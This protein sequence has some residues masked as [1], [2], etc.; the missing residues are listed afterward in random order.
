MSD[1][2]KKLLKH[3]SQVEDPDTLTHIL[4]MADHIIVDNPAELRAVKAE[5]LTSAILFDGAKIRSWDA[6]RKLI[7]PVLLSQDPELLG[8]MIDVIARRVDA[9]PLDTVFPDLYPDMSYVLRE[10]NK[11]LHILVSLGIISARAET[12]EASKQLVDKINLLRHDARFESVADDV[13][14]ELGTWDPDKIAEKA[15]LHSFIQTDEARTGQAVDPGASIDFT[16]STVDAAAD[17]LGLKSLGVHR[18]ETGAVIRHKSKWAE[19]ADPGDPHVPESVYLWFELE[20]SPEMRQALNQLPQSAAW[21]RRRYDDLD[22]PV[23]PLTKVPSLNAINDEYLRQLKADDNFQRLD[24]GRWTGVLRSIRDSGSPLMVQK[25]SDKEY[26]LFL[27]VHARTSVLDHTR[28]GILFQK[29]PLGEAR[30]SWRLEDG[31][32]IITAL[33]EPDFTSFIHEMGHLLRRDLNQQQLEQMASWLKTKNIEVEID[34]M[35]RFIGDPSVVENAEETFAKAFEVYM[36]TRNTDS[37]WVSRMFQDIQNALGDL[38][39][40]IN[41]EAVTPDD[42]MVQ[43]FDNLVSDHENIL[44]TPTRSA[45]HYFT[46]LTRSL[47]RTLRGRFTQNDGIAKDSAASYIVREARHDER[48]LSIYSVNEAGEALE[49]LTTPRQVSRV[50]E[51]GRNIAFF[52]KPEETTGLENL[53]QVTPP[54]RIGKPQGTDPKDNVFTPDH[55]ERLTRTLTDKLAAGPRES[56]AVTNIAQA[57]TGDDI[58]D[59]MRRNIE[60]KGVARKI[61]RGVLTTFVGGDPFNV[62]GLSALPDITRKAILAGTRLVENAYGEASRLIVDASVDKDWAKVYAF[63]AGDPVT[64]KKGRQVV[65]SGYNSMEQAQLSLA[66]WFKTSGLNEQWGVISENFHAGRSA[67]QLDPDALDAIIG[68]FTDSK[69]PDFL[70]RIL[71]SMT[72]GKPLRETGARINETDLKVL[73]KIFVHL[74]VVDDGTGIKPPPTAVKDWTQRTQKLFED[75]DAVAGEKGPEMKSRITMLI[76]GFGNL[77]RAVDT[78]SGLG[79]MQSADAVKSFTRYLDA[80]PLTPAEMTQA[81]RLSS[82]FGLNKEFVE[83]DGLFRSFEGYSIPE[84]A[85]GKLDEALARGEITAGKWGIQATTDELPGY[86]SMFIRYMKKRMTRGAYVV[87]QRYFLMNTIDHFFQMAGTPGVGFRTATA[88]T[89]RM[90]LQNIMAFP[91]MELVTLL[92]KDPEKIRETL[93]KGG[94]RLAHNIGSFLSQSKWRVDVND[95]LKG[96]DGHVTIA[97]NVYTHKQLRQMAIEEG[98][99]SSFDQSELSSAIGN[100]L[101]EYRH[102]IE[103]TSGVP[104]SVANLAKDG[105]RVLSQNIDDIAEAWGERERL[106]AMIT[107]MERGVPP[108]RAARLTIDALYDYAGTMSRGDRHFIVS[109]FLPFW[110]FQKNANQQFIRRAFSPEGAY[111]MGVLRRGA[112]YGSQALETLWFG[113]TYDPYGVDVRSMPPDLRDRYMYFR[114][115]IEHGYGPIRGNLPPLMLNPLLEALGVSSIE[116]LDEKLAEGENEELARK[117]YI[118]ENGYGGI[119]NVPK[120]VIQGIRM[121][122]TRPGGGA[123]TLYFEEG[124]AYLHG[125]GLGGISPALQTLS[126]GSDGPPVS[127]FLGPLVDPA[128]RAGFRRHRVGVAVPPRMSEALRAHLRITKRVNQDDLPYAEFLLPESAIYSGLNHAAYLAATY[129]N[130]FSSIYSISPLADEARPAVDIQELMKNSFN[131]VIDVNRAPIPSLAASTLGFGPEEGRIPRRL[132]PSLVPIV[133]SAFPGL[134]LIKTTEI[135]ALMDAGVNEAQREAFIQDFASQMGLEVSEARDILLAKDRRYYMPPG[136]WSFVMENTPLFGEL[137]RRML[138]LEP[139]TGGTRDPLDA[140]MGRMGR[141]MEIA[142]LTTG[143]ETAR[144]YRHRQ[145]RQEDPRFPVTSVEPSL[146]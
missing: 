45:S 119:E 139:L 136:T 74:G 18:D 16:Q 24:Q 107:L 111:R 54:P 110:A 121:A 25:I 142:R 95:V 141:I 144:V 32:S 133:E 5:A 105:H 12:R 70:K 56:I 102:L 120:S 53:T 140:S 134:D 125:S 96:G 68:K 9:D 17:V 72:D 69:V 79:L 23:M 60:G 91:G 41:Y 86:A 116:E 26:K 103:N 117:L 48:N 55:A 30:S 146:D 40:S 97:G 38:L 14:F 137:N 82:L 63:L 43:I 108:R 92:H 89:A 4:T 36:S 99:F 44:K 2:A 126:D 59:Q 46:E 115:T 11:G 127:D 31:K 138:D 37:P 80:E 10:V 90:M 100:M 112:E 50:F 113:A 8:N 27:Q 131:E 21:E 39:R 62:H 67:T 114:K 52:L 83:A 128:G 135:N 101:D 130:L 132:S 64:F 58:V 47:G 19:H 73:D 88:S 106:G 28:G 34:D 118:I 29:G 51:N 20:V 65:S 35:G 145:A 87:R 13:S 57:A 78:W 98:I 66:D 22:N 93:Q 71:K 122:L 33:K 6:R 84:A 143:V 76:T 49:E 15:R 7:D 61:A 1:E 81:S 85:K 104:S 109:L 94:D 42:A 3:A 124:E 129:A 77:Q 123:G 75:I